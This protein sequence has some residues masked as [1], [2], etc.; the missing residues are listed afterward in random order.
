M[1][2]HNLKKVL[3]FPFDYMWVCVNIVWCD[4]NIADNASC[5]ILYRLHVFLFQLLFSSVCFCLL[6]WLYTRRVSVSMG[7]YKQDCPNLDCRRLVYSCAIKVRYNLQNKLIWVRLRRR[8][9]HCGESRDLYDI[10]HAILL[11]YSYFLYKRID[12]Y[13]ANCDIP[14][15]IKSTYYM[16]TFESN[17]IFIIVTSYFWDCGFSWHFLLFSGRNTDVSH[18]GHLQQLP[19]LLSVL[20]VVIKSGI[21]TQ[22]E[23]G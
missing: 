4:E 19:I 3:N 9:K 14:P 18:F 7:Q 11:W 16:V 22:G 12:L 6:R 15:V 20:L 23:V 5:Y 10:V 1:I 21:G 8:S 17:T 2:R 13:A